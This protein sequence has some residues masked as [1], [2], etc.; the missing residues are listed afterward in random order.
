MSRLTDSPTGVADSAGA[1]G[2]GDAD[3]CVT[4][5]RPSSNEAAPRLCCQERIH[6]EL[7]RSIK[8]HGASPESRQKIVLRRHRHLSHGSS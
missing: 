3:S 6:R 2:P 4:T 5:E 1:T 7:R 8:A